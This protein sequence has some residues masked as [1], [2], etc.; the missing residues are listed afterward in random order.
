MLPAHAAF[1]LV[2][3]SAI[4]SPRRPD[5]STWKRTRCGPFGT[6]SD[7]L[8]KDGARVTAVPDIDQPFP[9]PQRI[10]RGGDWMLL[11]GLWEWE[12]APSN[13]KSL[14][15]F[16]PVPLLPNEILP[17]FGRKLNRSIRVPFSVAS[18]LSGVAPQDSS[19]IY[20]TVYMFYRLELD[21][22]AT[23][24]KR[25]VLHFDAVDANTTVWLNGRL[26]GTHV[27]GFSRFSFDITQYLQPSNELLLHVF[28]ASDRGAAPNG[29]QQLTALEQPSGID[30]APVSGIWQSVWIETAPEAVAVEELTVTGSMAGEVLATAWIRSTV[31]TNMTV[32]V[33]R[34]LG[35]NGSCSAPV[36]VSG[37]KQQKISCRLT[38]QNP[39]LWDLGKPFLYWVTVVVPYPGGVEIV[40]SYVGL[41]TF[42]VEDGVTTLNGKS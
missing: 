25:H 12:P 32:L 37:V 38:L 27:G 35:V 18:C 2:A 16:G 1:V 21:Y 29:K 6:T 7:L 19:E 41:R 30:Y 20:S 4:F 10:R 33:E 11:D 23:V 26:L 9:L 31:A 28:D 40:D 24:G 5:P 15:K 13:V 34:T 22:N 8:T 14:D 3:L 39:V 36:A 42:A 17:P